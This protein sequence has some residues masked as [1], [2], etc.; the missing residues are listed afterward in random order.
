[1]Q[2]QIMSKNVY[3]GLERTVKTVTMNWNNVNI[4]EN[5]ETKENWSS[6]GGDVIS[7][8]QT[9]QVLLKFI[10]K[11]VKFKGPAESMQNKIYSKS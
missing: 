10:P 3:Y 2:M 8:A 1:M 11:Q 4:Y 7:V 5:V 6:P 9:I